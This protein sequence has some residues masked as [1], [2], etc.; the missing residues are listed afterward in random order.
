MNIGKSIQVQLSILLDTNP[1]VELLDPMVTLFSICS[2]TIAIFHNE[3]IRQVTEPQHYRLEESPV[4]P[5]EHS[6]ASTTL[7]SSLYLKCKQS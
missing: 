1:E 2:G 4:L 5:P 6:P 3:K 7:T